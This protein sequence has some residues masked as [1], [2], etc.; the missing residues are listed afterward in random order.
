M[1]TALGKRVNNRRKEGEFG[2]SV[3]DGSVSAE[4]EFTAAFFGGISSSMSS[5]RSVNKSTSTQIVGK[6]D[7]AWPI[8]RFVWDFTTPRRRRQS[9]ATQ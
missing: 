2:I 9:I 6:R 5:C 1:I 7:L 3:V 8:R 4:I